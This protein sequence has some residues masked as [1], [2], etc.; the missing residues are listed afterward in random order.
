MYRRV[1]LRTCFLI[2]FPVLLPAQEDG[3]AERTKLAAMLPDPA[4]FG[5][6]LSEPVRFYSSDLYEYN[7]GGAEIYHLYGLVALAHQEFK[8]KGAAITVDVYDMGK[9]RQA[10]GIYSVERAANYR[11]IDIGAEGYASAQLVNFVQGNYYVKI[12]SFAD[13]TAAKATLLDVARGISAKIGTDRS[14]PREVAWFPPRGLVAHSRKY[15]M[16]SPMGRDYLAPAAAAMYR[17]DGRETTLVVSFAAD[18]GGAAAR[19]GR[20][21][22]SFA[23]SAGVRGMPVEAWR[24]R[25][26]DEG[27]LL[28][29]ARGRYAV[30]ILEPPEQPEAFVKELLGALP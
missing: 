8:T 14:L 24:G 22:Q 20:L 1:F 11:F 18:S 9:P 12:L 16:R 27:D 7:D 28:F 15:I 26:R 21:K 25:S 10:F 13:E 19:V 5:G 4:G 17:L 3:A 29:F 6:E 23:N 2:A 30:L